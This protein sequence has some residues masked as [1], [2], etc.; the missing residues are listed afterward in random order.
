[1][2]HSTLAPSSASRRMQ[3]PG[4]RAMTELF[5][6]AQD[7]PRAL[8]G[9]I[10]H[11]V[12]EAVLNNLPLPD[13]HTEEM[14]D[15]ADLWKATIEK[16]ISRSKSIDM[17]FEK[18]MDIFS[19]HQSC[20]G[21]PDFD[22]YDSDNHCLDVVD[23]KFGHR[24]VSEYENWQLIEYAVGA[25]DKYGPAF[26]KSGKRTNDLIV[27]L[28]IV[29]PRS[30]HKDGPVRTWTIDGTVMNEYFKR[31]RE[32]ELRS[33][34]ADAP[35]ITGPECRDCSA[36]HACSNLQ[37]AAAIEVEMSVVN[38]PFDMSANAQGKELST[39]RRAIAILEARASG[40]EDEVLTKVK[41]G[42]PVVGWRTEQS[43]GR[44]KWNKPIEEVLALGGMMGVNLEKPT[45][46]TPTQ[47]IKAGLSAEIVSQYSE[48]P[49]GEIKL[50]PDDL[51]R[52]RNV[53]NKE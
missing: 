34:E 46:I 5:P 16:I 39:L 18:R 50:V 17:S 13:G 2:I 35:V 9:V 48:T 19:I 15:G 25:I 1:M 43:Q 41:Q 26:V 42:H 30:Y 53:F 33:L 51:G 12:N 37:Q 47:A 21:T 20:F 8:E 38:A 22:A 28:T 36:R 24:H 23:Y 52:A 44:K 27:N 31:L 4:S 6:Q 11:K 45:A 29:Q 7:N 40:L 10:A 14:L 32:S 3:C 49:V